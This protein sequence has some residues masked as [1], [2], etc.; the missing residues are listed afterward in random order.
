[1]LPQRVPQHFTCL[2]VV[3]LRQVLLLSHK[4]WALLHLTEGSTL[5]SPASLLPY[6]FYSL[7]CPNRGLA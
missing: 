6:S 3:S 5:R 4:P 7:F 1:M 2:A